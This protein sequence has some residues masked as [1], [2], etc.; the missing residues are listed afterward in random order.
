MARSGEAFWWSL[1]SAGGVM[2]ALFAPVLIGLTGFL[3]PSADPAES[4]ERLARALA[5]WPARVVL[6]GVVT[7]SLFHCAHRIRH[8]SLDVGLRSLGGPIALICYMGAFVASVVA[9]VTL[10]SL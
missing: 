2:A 1:F 8:T 9:A 3:L 5:S 4:Y 6:L 7:L 10:G